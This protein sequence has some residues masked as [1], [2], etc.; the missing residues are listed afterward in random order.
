MT[1]KEVRLEF[2]GSNMKAI[3]TTTNEVIINNITPFDTFVY[4]GET[5]FIEY[6]HHSYTHW[7]FVSDNGAKVRKTI[8]NNMIIDLLI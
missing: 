5:G 2:N 4:Q 1:L 8:T 7:K 6:N 3:D